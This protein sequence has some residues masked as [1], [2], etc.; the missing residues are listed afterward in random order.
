MADDKSA[1][2]TQAVASQEAPAQAHGH[3]PAVALSDE[4]ACLELFSDHYEDNLP[5]DVRAKV[6]ERLRVDGDFAKAYASFSATME[7]LSGMHKMS[8]PVDFGDRVEDTIHRRSGGR[9]FGRKAFGER[10]PYEILA[11]VVMLIAALVY[12]VGRSSSTG[13]HKLND[14]SRPEIREPAPD[15]P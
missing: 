7:A 12:W 15:R 5:A 9:F 13:S 6:D 10:I 1:D 8:A 14:G 2:E 11:V 4:D 3:D